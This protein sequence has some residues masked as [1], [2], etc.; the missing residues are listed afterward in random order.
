M[1]PP[2]LF[3]TVAVV[4]VGVEVLEP[5][6]GHYKVKANYGV[7]EALVLSCSLL[8]LHRLTNLLIAL[9]PYKLPIPSKTSVFLDH[10]APKDFSQGHDPPPLTNAAL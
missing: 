2:A 1:L 6:V 9:V 5:Q 3:Y 10:P 7:Y 8:E 4:W